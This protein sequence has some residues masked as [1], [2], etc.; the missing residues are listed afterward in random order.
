MLSCII[1]LL[2]LGEDIVGG[3]GRWEKGLKHCIYRLAKRYEE[4]NG[5]DFFSVPVAPQSEP[6]ASSTAS[7]NLA[8]DKLVTVGNATGDESLL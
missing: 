8:A 5:E 7:T 2:Y 4:E 3:F 6:Q 1:I